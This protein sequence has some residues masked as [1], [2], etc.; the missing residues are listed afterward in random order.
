L[1][2]FPLLNLWGRNL[3]VETS[4][5]LQKNSLSFLSKIIVFRLYLRTLSHLFQKFIHSKFIHSLIE[6]SPMKVYH[7]ATCNTCQRIIKELDLTSKATLQ[8]IKEEQITPK[9]LDEMKALSGSYEA[10]FSRRAM[11]YRSMG[12]NEMQL[13]E[14][15]YRKY[16]LQEYTFLK[17]PVVVTDNQVFIGNS[18][19]VIESLKAVL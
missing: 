9:Q 13:K 1:A 17:R 19:K 5:S 15:D 6:N 2:R 10:L 4:L 7:L 12:L 3:C 11:K 18:K 16:I 14:D 8:N